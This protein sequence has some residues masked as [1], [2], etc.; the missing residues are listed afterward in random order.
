MRRASRSSSKRMRKA[1]RKRAG[2]RGKASRPARRTARTRAPRSQ[3]RPRSRPRRRA[4][5]QAS[6]RSAAEIEQFL[7]ARGLEKVS[8]RI[9]L[10]GTREY[11]PTTRG[12]KA[13]R[14]TLAGIS[15]T[16]GGAIYT[17]DI[18]IRY[19]DPKT[20]R[21]KT[22]T[23]EGLGVPRPQ[24]VAKLPRSK[25]TRG[26]RRL[27]MA[28]ARRAIH[29]ELNTVFKRDSPKKRRGAKR[30]TARAAYQ[31]LLK[32]KRE[33]SARVRFTFYREGR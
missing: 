1:A 15:S 26:V 21:F 24:D 8:E 9:K 18:R 5:P 11:T 23:I 10:G 29:A 31:S 19:R 33:R 6:R 27:F 3:G 14:E 16:K 20:G 30:M 28:E 32:F 13:V 17:A 4:E 25:R 22:R 7:E 2:S 12:Y